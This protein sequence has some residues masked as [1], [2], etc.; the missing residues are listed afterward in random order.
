MSPVRT[1]VSNEMAGRSKMLSSSWK[2]NNVCEN[3]SCIGA[4]EK[5]LCYHYGMLKLY[6][7]FSGAVAS[8]IMSKY[9]WEEGQGEDSMAIYNAMYVC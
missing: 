9:G 1:C 5:S 4:I 3:W 7:S 8:K 2:A 6:L